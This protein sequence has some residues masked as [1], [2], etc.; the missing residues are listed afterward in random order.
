MENEKQSIFPQQIPGGVTP[1]MLQKASMRS[2][3]VYSLL[4]MMIPILI[5][6]VIIYTSTQESGMQ[7]INGVSLQNFTYAAENISS[8][9]GRLDYAAKTAFS[10]ENEIEVDAEGHVRALSDNSLCAALLSLEERITPEVTALFYIKGDNHIYS[11]SGRMLYGRYEQGYLQ[12]YNLSLSALYTRLQGVRDPA[13]WPLT[14]REDISA[15]SGLVYAI[16]FPV[17][18]SAR[19][20]LCFVLSDS[21]LADQFANYMGDLP[22]SL[23]CFDAWHD[24]LYL[25]TQGYER[26]PD[27]QLIRVRGTGVLS[28][29]Y[30]GEDW[31]LMR[32]GSSGSLG[33]YWIMATPRAD[34]YA[35]LQGSQ[36][37]IMTLLLALL[38]L[39][40][41]LIVAIAF[42]NYKPIQ[43]LL[44][45]V[46]GNRGRS[47]TNELEVIRGAYD[48]TADEVESLS[49]YLNEITPIVAQQFV[50]RLVFGR[51]SGAQDI[52]ALAGQA[53][54]D[55]SRPL[56]LV[57]YLA[58]SRQKEERQWEQAAMIASRFS[59]MGAYAAL[60]DLSVES[61]LCFVINF[62]APP[63]E[64]DQ[65][66]EEYARQ[67]YEYMEQNGAAPEMIGIG[68]VYQ[69]PLKMNESFVEACAA[70]QL[71]PASAHWW[72][73]NAGAADALAAGD[74]FHGLSPLSL[75]LLSEGIHHGD[76][77]TA[78]RA[79]HD[80]LK[81]I[82]DMTHS[83]VFYRFCCSE[84]LTAVI[85]QADS[86]NL[87]IGK[88]RIQQLVAFA[89]PEDFEQEAV[90]LVEELCDAM[91]QRISDDDQR[92]KQELMD[93]IL[94][95]FKR[96]DLSIQT[97]A[98]ET[99][100]RKAQITALLK[101]ETGQG[102]VQ[103]VSYLRLNEF[104][105]LLLRSDETIRD[106][107]LKIGYSDVPNFL[108]KFKSI[109]G[110]TPSQYRQ[111]H[112]KK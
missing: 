66:A 39:M 23:Y 58:L 65:R 37:L 43:E 108:R 111:Q 68:N 88:G 82:A 47:R 56:N 34:Y 77:P 36:R 96:P 35:D 53:G 38:V 17:E 71:A 95:N 69:D 85:R 57:M 60:G 80:M 33:C 7:Y 99:G 46:T 20:V 84:L 24:L 63:E 61:A 51:L 28:Y 87:P 16:P 112:G 10:I 44:Y 64:R 21:I 98:D 72:R 89:A 49:S 4:L 31:V 2:R 19:A 15:L 9:I 1:P 83:L 105:R 81:N 94:A 26:I 62:D 67:L 6:S 91:K 109:E 32:S 29:R 103:Y 40:L 52:K 42:F 102:F 8:L 78:L 74:G 75:S 13:L 97:V 100:I 48:Q 79:L 86:L 25:D 3:Y 92:L 76:K 14:S 5:F 41:I 22:G 73:Y 54:M 45:H 106:L 90:R 70:V 55:F 101:E 107:V 30:Q 18:S 110:V 11:S 27:S 104:K 12:D 93:Y 50:S 59:L